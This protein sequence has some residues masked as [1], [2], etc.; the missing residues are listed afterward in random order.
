MSSQNLS[1]NELRSLLENDE[2][3]MSVVFSDPSLPDNPMIYVSDA[4][5]SQ[6]GYAPEEALGRNCR[7]L[8]GEDTDPH[9]VEAIRQALRAQTT[10]TIDILNYRKDGTAF[11]N[12]L[13]IRPIYGDD[14]GLMFF[15]GAQNP[16]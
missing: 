2:T 16:V 1:Q 6:T 10:F 15:A 13:R 8:Q 14:G 7:F 9:A 12:R 3:E 5:E 4:F 11:V